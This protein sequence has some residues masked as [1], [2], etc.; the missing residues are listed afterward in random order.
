MARNCRLARSLPFAIIQ[1]TR[2]VSAST[3]SIQ[4]T[5]HRSVPTHPSVLAACD[6]LLLASHARR[7]LCRTSGL[8]TTTVDQQRRD[9]TPAREGQ[10]L[11]P[12]GQTGKRWLAAR[13]DSITAK[14]AIAGP[15]GHS[16]ASKQLRSPYYDDDDLG[17]SCLGRCAPGRRQARK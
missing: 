2:C 15:P 7:T 4:S 14:Q 6:K 5:H 9:E 11:R 12:D 16:Q 1:V 3:D 17:A 8:L 13:K 10:Q